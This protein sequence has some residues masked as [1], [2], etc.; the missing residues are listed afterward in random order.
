MVST[1]FLIILWFWWVPCGPASCL[2]ACAVLAPTLTPG[3]PIELWVREGPDQL[4][5][6]SPHRFEKLATVLAIESP[7]QEGGVVSADIFAAVW[8][9]DPRAERPTLWAKSLQL[10]RTISGSGI[11]VDDDPTA[12]LSNYVGKTT[13]GTLVMLLEIGP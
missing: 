12:D 2:P 9:A 11:S 7:F 4:F 8:S 1:L 13:D 10:G 3:A 5:Q 6:P